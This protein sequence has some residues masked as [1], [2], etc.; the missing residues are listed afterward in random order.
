MKQRE[1]N[2]KYSNTLSV[3]CFITS[4]I[5]PIFYASAEEETYEFN[6]GFIMGSKDNVDLDRFNATGIS[7]GKYSVD[8][9]T[10]NDWKGRY[11][12]NF[13]EQ[14]N[15]Q[16]GVCYTPELLSNLGIDTEKFNSSIDKNSDTCLPLDEWNSDKEVKDI[17]HTSTLRLDISVPQIYEQKIS[18]GYVSPQFWETGIPALNIGYMA[19]YYDSHISGNQGS[20]SS[21]AY[22]GIN[23]GL[24]YDGWLLKHI[25]NLSWQRSAGS[26]W[27]SNQT[28][29]QRPIAALKSKATVGQFYTDGNLFD[30]FGLRGVKLTTDDNMYPDGMTTYAPE[31]R[32]IA[33]SNAL[34]TIRQ[35]G[36]IIYQTTVSPGPFSLNDVY[37]SGYGNDLNVTV[38]EADGSETNFSVPYSSLAQLLRPGF[39]R[40]QI[41]GGKSD[42]ENLKNRPFVMQ[43]TLQHGINNTFT[44][45]GGVTA[46]D[47]YQAY[48]LGS[49]INTG[50]GAVAI[51]VT[52]SRIV[53]NHRTD[54]GQSYRFT[55]NKLFTETD[56]NLVLAAY[57]YSTKDYYNINNA[58]YAIDNDKRGVVDTLGREKNGFSYTINQNLPEGYGGIY[59][60]GR[61][62]SYWDKSG[63][64]K[65]Y[66]LSYNN[67]INRLSYGLSFM[68]VYTQNSHDKKDD[69]I[70]VNL[71]IPLYWGENQV[72]TLTSNTT[73]NNE[74][75]GSSQIGTSGTFDRDNNW[76]YGINTS[77]ANGGAKNIGLNT[78]Y[79]TSSANTNAN[80]SQ[81]EGYRQYGVGANGSLV[82]HSGGITLTPNNATT[83]ALI[84]AK[85]A[86]G[87]SV[88]GAMGTTIDSH[89]YAIAPYVRAYR[90][91]KI[92]IDPKGSSENIIFENMSSQIVPYEGS[93]VKV[94]FGTKI[95]K[96]VIY[97]VKRPNNKPLPFGANVTDQKGESIGIVGQGG[98]VFISSEIATNAIIT[99]DK[100][101]CTFSLAAGN[102]KEV[103]CQ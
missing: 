43:A 93:V 67:S 45:Y 21:S 12:L 86:E 77:V 82:L 10:N 60:M 51:D 70:G 87:A 103:L 100:G 19:N 25:G 63:T 84:E 27:N 65:Q 40:Y 35:N 14:K 101:Q 15:K 90:T 59:F 79:R 41:A 28:Y 83:I 16:L 54:Y 78:S 42:S 75:F 61:I 49:G 29:L 23:A 96:N 64:E 94:K 3:V 81:G 89:G 7:P 1:L 22:L 74:K 58:L 46:F 11:E 8:V 66:Q 18:R 88:V 80:Y 26:D 32:G 71:S 62:S 99:W 24:S 39:T 52:Q 9:Y 48:L 34:V 85:G 36:N 98:M 2:N 30:S 38:K 69:R 92:E 17:F 53:F 102:S 95:E 55:F 91:N 20:D 31:I 33:Q 47:D 97:N 44:L 5:V 6:S 37:P 72:S 76:T 56:T 50:V 13:E 57:R 73:F 4:W 68:R